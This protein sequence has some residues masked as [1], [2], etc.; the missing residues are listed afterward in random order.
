MRLL[1]SNA[2]WLMA[3]AAA[4]HLSMAYRL[5]NKAN[6]KAG[7]PQSAAAG[8]ALL[9]GST[10]KSF[11]HAQES[12]N[13]VDDDFFD[14]AAAVRSVNYF[15][16]RKCNYSCQFCFHTQKNTHHLSLDE[17]QRGLRLLQQAGCQKINFAGGESE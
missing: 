12:T 5:P 10:R 7:P 13:N 6:A 1:F 15:I 8:R 4:P 9:A 11:L 16:S 2:H 3:L 17:A 14:P